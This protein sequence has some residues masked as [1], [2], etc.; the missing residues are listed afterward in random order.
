MNKISLAVAAALALVATPVMAQ[1]SGFYAGVGVG[2]FGVE[3]NNFEDTLDFDENDTG[4]RVFG[5]WQFNQYFGIEAGYNAGPEPSG[6]IGDIATDGIEADVSIELSGFDLY[7]VGTLPIGESFY[8]FA[9][10]GM[11]AWDAD[12]DAV[13]REDDGDGGV[14]TTTF[15]DDT[16]GEDFAYGAGFGFNISENA[17]VQIDYTIYDFNGT[18]GDVLS[19]NFVW[20]FN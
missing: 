3:E 20:K 13:V 8:A 10:A 1:D 5:G 14:I 6:T 4:F 16:S 2:Q 11:I 7:A 17:K 9:K 12:I 18:D 19:G 15:S